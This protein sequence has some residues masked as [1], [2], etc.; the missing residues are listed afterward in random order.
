MA[1]VTVQLL[2]EDARDA[3]LLMAQH[4]AFQVEKGDPA[5][6][7]LPDDPAAEYRRTYASARARLSKIL[8]HTTLPDR[9]PPEV[10]DAPNEGQLADIDRQ[11]GALWQK[12]SEREEQV[13][14][15]REHKQH[16]E[17]QLLS[18]ENFQSLKVDL[19]RLRQDRTFLDLRVGTVPSKQYARFEEAMGLAGFTISRFL[20][21]NGAAHVILAGQK[22]TV[23]GIEPVLKAAG[24]HALEIP[25]NFEDRP[26]EIRSQLLAESAQCDADCARL[27]AEI[28]ALCQADAEPL[29]TAAA[30]IELASPYAQLGDGLR[31]RG[32][33]ALIT[34]WVPRSAVEGLQAALESKLKG[35]VLMQQRHP[36]P[37]ES[38]PSVLRHH[39][40]LSPFVRLV[41]NY[42]V[43]RYG[44]VDPTVVFAVSFIAMFGMMFG[45]IGHGAVIA[46]V[47]LPL[48]RRL[49]TFTPFLIACGF[50]SMVFGALYGS[51]FGF[52]EWVHPLWISPLTDPL[53]MLRVALY[54][55]IGFILV[56]SLLTVYNQ[57]TDRHYLAALLGGSGLA[58]ISLY[59]SLIWLVYGWF[60]QGRWSVAPSLLAVLGLIG[61]MGYLWHKNQRPLG[62]RILTVIIETLETVMSYVSGSLS[63]LRVAAFSLNHV[64]LAAAVFAIAEMM[65]TVGHWITIVVGNL[66]ILVLEGAIVGI[67]VIRLEYYEGFSR[68][69]HGDG[70]AFRPLRVLQSNPRSPQSGPHDS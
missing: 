4:G 18:L 30:Q 39:R 59:L 7:G 55:G 61:V 12:I 25:E 2:A 57:L 63:F 67:Q 8:N 15:C 54:W 58:G 50:S 36:L 48:R 9:H 47:A 24:W 14:L 62:E 38:V 60:A 23:T 13:R 5:N 28:R 16:I 68:F 1:R 42:G 40:L 70:R 41:T 10:T 35:P 19:G 29:A 65:N 3:S 53:L 31:A 44:E 27:Q 37:D 64:A 49:G 33:L 52:E 21:S 17:R 34:G 6:P 22:G 46:I 45:D 20:E 26:E 11:L 32:G 56:A 69:Y 66:F 51:V 43:P